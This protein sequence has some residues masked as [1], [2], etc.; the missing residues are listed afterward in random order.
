MIT[1]EDKILSSDTLS[2]KGDNT[3]VK[4]ILTHDI[5]GIS[6]SRFKLEISLD[7]EQENIGRITSDLII[8]NLWIG[9]TAYVNNIDEAI[10]QL[11]YIA[12]ADEV[13]KLEKSKTT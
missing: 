1:L 13:K 8:R 2:I 3:L 11:R 10:N 9:M 6:S 12:Y 4:K 7:S 5:S